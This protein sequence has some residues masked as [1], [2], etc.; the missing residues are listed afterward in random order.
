MSDEVRIQRILPLD[1][2]ERHVLELMAGLD[3]GVAPPPPADAGPDFW[4][5][6]LGLIASHRLAELVYSRRDRGAWWEAWPEAA[7]AVVR[8][9]YIETA[10]RNAFY[11]RELH[12]VAAALAARGLPCVLLKGAALTLA[13]TEDPDERPYGD[14]DLLLPEERLDDA[15][16]A[17]RGL[18]YQLDDRWRPREFYRRHHFH[19]IYRRAGLPWCRFE[20]HWNL[21]SA[22]MDARFDPAALLAQARPAALDGQPVAVLAPVDFLL[23]L[24]LHAAIG[25]FNYLGQIRDVHVLLAR[26]GDE[27]EPSVLW[28]RADAARVA[29]P[30]WVCLSLARLWGPQ[31]AAARLLAARPPRPGGALM[32]AMVRPESL[33]RQRVKHSTVGNTAMAMMRRDRWPVRLNFLR[34]Q[35]RP[36]PGGLDD[37]GHSGPQD[38]GPNDPRLLVRRAWR[39]ALA[40]V[41]VA[42]AACG[43]EAMPRPPARPRAVGSP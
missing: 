13:V 10:M 30:L 26:Q 40:L 8:Q 29:T 22:A 28:A 4:P 21:A 37:T 24:C 23:H 43:L 7:R 20:L 34:R 16:A 14:I 32:Q 42:L 3:Q 41:W 5:R 36:S 33:L 6:V 12:Q 1:A 18:G 39:A 35:L 19:L 27:L 2:A 31:P 17:M 11:R 25:G 9:H 38:H 15:D